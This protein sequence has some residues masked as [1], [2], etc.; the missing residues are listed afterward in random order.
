ML[1]RLVKIMNKPFCKAPFTGLTINP[2]HSMA[3]CCSDSKFRLQTEL[4]DIS[5]LKD[6]F[7]GPLMSS[8]REEFRTTP[9]KRYPACLE[10]HPVEDG[11]RKEINVYDERFTQSDIVEEPIKLR[12]LEI[13]TSNICNQSCVMCSPVYSTQLGKLY[14]NEY[15]HLNVVKKTALSAKDLDNI[16]SVLPDLE[17]LQIKGGEP[18]ADKNNYTILKKLL[19]VN[20]ACKVIFTS[21]GNY[22][23]N[24]YLDL[25]KGFSAVDANFSIDGYDEIY[26]WVRG[27]K[28]EKTM[29]SIHKYYDTTG[30]KFSTQSAITAITLS[31]VVQTV[32]RILELPGLKSINISNVVSNPTFLDP[33]MLRPDVLDPIVED[34]TTY[35]KYFSY[36]AGKHNRPWV[37]GSSLTHLKSFDEETRQKLL[38][39]FRERVLM[40]NRV[41]NVD[42]CKYV[43]EVAGLL[44]AAL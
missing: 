23:P 40:F 43:P 19:D 4:K 10:C 37:N 14:Q 11:F 3:M 44:N 16:Y 33:R 42:I 28:F 13:S 25:F 21:N 35:L 36:D 8:V 26:A 18:F 9:L 41:R 34:I 7:H 6:F 15:P 22:I 39:I 2:T 5:N 29:A 24:E 27:G 32:E 31:T 17:Y 38:P 1:T 20:P 12:Y 30:F